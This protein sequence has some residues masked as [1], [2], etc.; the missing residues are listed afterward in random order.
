MPEWLTILI[1]IV[2]LLGTLFGIFGV[3]SYLSERAK[4]KAQ[5]KSE[6]EDKTEEE[7]AAMYEK[8]R[9]DDIEAILNKAL[10]TKLAPISAKLEDVTSDIAKL[11][12]GVQVTCRNDLEELADEADNKKWISR[13]D[14]DRFETAYLAYHDLGKNGVMDATYRRIMDLPE[15]KPTSNRKPRK[16]ILVEDNNK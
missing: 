16:K 14:K 9:L 2:G 5:K 7:I 12:S 1:A 6:K 13:Y 4:H 10:D 3:S 15:S 11:K 8:K